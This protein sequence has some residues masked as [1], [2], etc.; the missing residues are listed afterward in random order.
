MRL[1]DFQRCKRCFP[2]NGE[3]YIKSC[4]CDGFSRQTRR[5]IARAIRTVRSYSSCAET[6][7]IYSRCHNSSPL[8]I[9]DLTKK[10]GRLLYACAPMVRYSK[11]AFRQTVHA[12]GTDLCW[13][14]MILAKEF[15]RSFIARDSG[16]FR[17]ALAMLFSS[18]K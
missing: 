4:C 14:P 17:H 1:Q 16:E 11:L 18:I 2:R 3:S 15:N 6:T 10:Q 8:K 5:D 7:V 12:Y 13:T 9:F